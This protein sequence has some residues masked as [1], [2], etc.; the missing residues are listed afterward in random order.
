MSLLISGRLDRI[1]RQQ[2]GNPGKELERVTLVVQ[3]WGQ[4]FYADVARDFGS[5]PGEGD[6]VAIEVIVRTY[7]RADG[8]PG[9][10]FTAVRQNIDAGKA[11]APAR[12]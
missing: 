4:T 3:D 6:D 11:L 2:V 12:A 7:K 8:S 1:Q 9:Y 5:L 10:A